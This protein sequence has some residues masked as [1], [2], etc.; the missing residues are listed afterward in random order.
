MLHL[1]SLQDEPA[2]QLERRL[3]QLL[4]CPA[5]ISTTPGAVTAATA[6][7]LKELIADMEDDDDG[8]ETDA[9]AAATAATTTRKYQAYAHHY[10]RWEHS[11][12]SNLTFLFMSA[13]A[14]SASK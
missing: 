13:T 14:L 11:F 12:H 8:D 2:I 10:Y 9:T 3:L 6:R 5:A 7:P 1:L 4:S